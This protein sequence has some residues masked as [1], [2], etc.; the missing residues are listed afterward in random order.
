MCPWL[1]TLQEARLMQLYL[2]EPPLRRKG[3]VVG[4]GADLASDRQRR[5]MK[6][7]CY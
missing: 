6:Y 3:G 7:V 4:P 5:G 1:C 2:A